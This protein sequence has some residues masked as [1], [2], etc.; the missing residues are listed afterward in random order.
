MR[1]SKLLQREDGVKITVITVNFNNLNG[2]KRTIPSVFSQTYN[3]YEYIIVDGGSTDG[4][5]EYIEQYSPLID[6][7]VSEPDKGVYNAMNKAIKMAHGEFCIFMNSGDHFY[8]PTV[9]DEVL[10]SLND[11]DICTGYT[12]RIGD[13]QVDIWAPPA[14][15]DMHFMMYDSLSHQ[16]T[17]TRTSILKERPFSEEYKIVSDW[18]S[19]FE[20]WYQQKCKYQMLDSTIAVYYWDGLS[21]NFDLWIKERK[22]VIEDIL[23][24]EAPSD[25][26]NCI[27]VTQCLTSTQMKRKK[28]F[29]Q[30]IKSAMNLSP[31]SRDMKILRNAFK[32]LIK[33]LLLK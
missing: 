6:E 19:F 32:C 9:L 20:A 7:W 31:V 33:D 11:A 8:S 3:Q 25:Y 27:N 26:G 13:K 21:G 22:L 4:S 28:L 16:A 14:E 24:K 5:K 2:L 10:P 1:N 29:E 30:K 12:L 17:F 15:L 18:E 23:G